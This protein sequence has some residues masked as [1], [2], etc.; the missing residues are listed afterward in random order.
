MNS[1]L[2]ATAIYVFLLVIFRIAGR[3][4]LGQMTTFDFVLLIIVSEAT[5]NAMLGEDNSLTNCF[6]VIL[7]LIGLDVALSLWKESSSTVE[8]LLEGV[9]MIIVEDGRPLKDRMKKARVGEDEVLTA[10]RQLQGLERMEQIKYAVLERSGAI[11]IIP[12]PETN[13]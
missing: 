10:A 8:K 4:T 2:H 13:A 5:Q 1:I 6:L 11:S 9:P 7:T 12:K 3:R